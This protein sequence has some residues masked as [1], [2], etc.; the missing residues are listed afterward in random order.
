MSGVGSIVPWNMPDI[1]W[2]NFSTN[3][4]SKDVNTEDKILA[5]T[6]NLQL[7]ISYTS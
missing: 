7:K 2:Y 5:R 1:P 3:H 4:Y 6:G